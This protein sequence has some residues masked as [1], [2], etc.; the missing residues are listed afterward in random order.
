M[1][2]KPSVEPLRKPIQCPSCTVK[3]SS[4]QHYPFCSKRCADMDL[5]QWFAGNYAFA[6]KDEDEFEL[7]HEPQ[8]PSFG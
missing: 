4:R 6:A 1:N 2:D 3:K 7:N 8:A 5:H